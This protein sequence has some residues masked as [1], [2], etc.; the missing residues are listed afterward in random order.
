VSAGDANVTDDRPKVF[1]SH[2][3]A[4][5]S[6][7]WP[8]VQ[9]LLGYGAA[10]W[11][12]ALEMRPGDDFSRRIS[13]AI[14]GSA[15]V[16]ALISPNSIK[17][18][19]VEQEV[20]QAMSSESQ[21]GRVRVIPCALGN[22]RMPAYLRDRLYCDFS[23]DLMRG[24]TEVLRGIYRDRHVIEI[25]LDAQK[26]LRL[27]ESFVRDELA[28]IFGLTDGVQ[29]F[30]FVLNCTDLLAELKAAWEVMPRGDPLT[31]FSDSNS[32][33]SLP[34]VI[35]NLSCILSKV[36]DITTQIFRR[37]A[38]LPDVLLAVLQ[39]AVTLTLYTFWTRVLEVTEPKAL[40]SLASV[41]GHAVLD[42]LA[43]I[44]TNTDEGRWPVRS[45]EAHVFKCAVD[46]LLELEFQGKAGI[47]DTRTNVPRVAIAADTPL[48]F[49][50]LAPDT[51]IDDFN[52]LRFFVPAI[53]MRQVI[54]SSFSGQYLGRYLE[55][56]G[57]RKGD[58]SHF[59]YP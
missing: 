6:G 5:K 16:L 15:Y 8:I 34:I 14:E 13:T 37:S 27:D 18:K 26:P 45:P 50:P 58:Y 1:V 29:R 59:G 22:V 9:A 33:A 48:G 46:N 12:D 57:M 36:A 35:P 2:S 10:P 55:R 51:E 3:S 28:R 41:R 19:W 43:E 30:F 20:R 56:V 31:V 44:N 40:A 17:S 52:W 25:R 42:G 24:L 49:H 38:D 7:A 39:R 23:G 4:D 32:P 53:A 54:V 21:D 11:V 47:F